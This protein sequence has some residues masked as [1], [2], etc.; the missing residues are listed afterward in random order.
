M[1]KQTPK[2][3]T[4]MTTEELS[5]VTE[6]FDKEFT[7]MRPLT[8]AERALHR[9]AGKMGRPPIGKGAAKLMI[10]V[11]RSLLKEADAFARRHNLKRSE[12]I[13]RGLRLAMGKT[14]TT[15]AG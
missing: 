14:P 5:K 6:V 9:K 8:P 10:S 11:E 3:F 12:L 7:P 4:E 2:K 15:K 1:S 13:A